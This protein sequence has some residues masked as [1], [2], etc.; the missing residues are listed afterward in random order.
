VRQTKNG[1]SFHRLGTGDGKS[2]QGLKAIGHALHRPRR[3]SKPYF[4]LGSRYIQYVPPGVSTWVGKNLR[5]SSKEGACGHDLGARTI[6]D[7]NTREEETGCL[8]F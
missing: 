2:E 1:R 8:F 4:L 5:E 3:L 7:P 6:P